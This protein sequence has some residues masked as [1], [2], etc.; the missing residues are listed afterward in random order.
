MLITNDKQ[1]KQLADDIAVND[2][3]VF[4]LETNGLDLWA[5]A[6]VI[7][8]AIYLPVQD[9]SYYIPI[10]HGIGQI[11]PLSV[12]DVENENWGKLSKKQVY[13]QEIYRQARSPIG[14]SDTVEMN[15]DRNMVVATI[16]PVW[17]KPH[18][19]I[20]HNAQF[21]LAG[22]ERL[23][24]SLPDRCLDTMVGAYTLF[25]GFASDRDGGGGGYVPFFPMAD[26]NTKQR[27]NLRLKW[28]ARLYQVGGATEGEDELTANV[29]ELSDQLATL[30]EQTYNKKG[31]TLDPKKHMWMLPPDKVNVYAEYDVKLTWGLYQQYLT[32]M[33]KYDVLDVFNTLCD[34]QY[35]AAYRMHSTGFEFDLSAAETMLETGNGLLIELE[36]K[37][38]V[39]LANDPVW[40]AHHGN[41]LKALKAIDEFNIN[42]PAQIT[43]YLVMHGEKVTN[44]DK[45]VLDD[46]RHKY[47]LLEYVLE[48]RELTKLLSSYVLKWYNYATTN[49]TTHLHPS[50]NVTST[51]TGRWSSSNAY[52]GNMQ[53]I[54]SEVHKDVSPKN[55][56]KP[57]NPDYCLVEVD[58]SQL[59]LRV[60]AWVAETVIGFNGDMTL[61]EHVKA[62]SLHKHTR[63]SIGV[64]AI[65][66]GK[67]LTEDNARDYLIEHRVNIEQ[68]ERDGY[69]PLT[70]FIEKIAYKSAKITNFLAMY[71]G[72]GKALS[73]VLK[74]PYEQANAIADGWRTTYPSVVNAMKVL[75]RLALTPRPIPNPSSKAD[76][77]RMYFHYPLPGLEFMRRYD[78]YDERLENSKG[79]VWNPRQ[80]QARNAFNSVVQG[81]A[82]LICTNSAMTISKTFEHSS[83]LMLHASV[84][85]SIVLSVHPDNLRVLRDVQRLMT[86]YPVYPGLAVD[87]EI[88][89]PGEAW[90]Y[91]QHVDNLDEL[92]ANGFN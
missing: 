51:V 80:A 89:K 7:G 32:I 62:N 59:E 2:Y 49:N 66:L 71:G 3:L 56:L 42:S 55:L 63:D 45:N 82:G 48:F 64:P 33:P 74:I 28:L 39:L 70:Y 58:Y 1:L 11:T 43:D 20:A 16:K 72:G 83:A 19:H 13:T 21:D 36:Q 31:I 23:G 5:S 44:A 37:A 79:G 67:E 12:E 68:I 9:M 29:G 41:S 92:I 10:G 77:R 88:C 78:L 14:F 60:G 52:V 26:T 69:T 91:K 81:T 18:T 46:Y 65:V 27:G 54:P 22:I 76:N 17:N 87:F 61:T 40:L 47:E 15:F 38:K 34:I 24:L 8:I 86:D 30:F 85:D 4:D 50:F 53:N 84:H 73:N 57:I 75:E 6:D 90:G 35:Y 25:S